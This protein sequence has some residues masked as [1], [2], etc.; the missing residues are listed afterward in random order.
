MIKTG[1]DYRCNRFSAFGSCL[2]VGFRCLYLPE[3]PEIFETP[4]R[5]GLLDSIILAVALIG[6]VLTLVQWPLTPYLSQWPCQAAA[7][8]LVDSKVASMR[9][10]VSCCIGCH[11]RIQP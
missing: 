5:L 7:D 2:A 3:H 11:E 8:P 9:R 10:F 4:G 1:L 6:R